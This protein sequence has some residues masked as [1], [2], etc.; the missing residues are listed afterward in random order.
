MEELN[1]AIT[2]RGKAAS[3]CGLGDVTHF[4]RSESG[5][6]VLTNSRWIL[7]DVGTLIPAFYLNSLKCFIS[8]RVIFS[9]Y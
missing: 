9:H 3:P 2:V 1:N 8:V 5:I 6:I 4:R 7:L